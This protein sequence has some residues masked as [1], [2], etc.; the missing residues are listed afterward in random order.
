MGETICWTC[1]NACPN[2]NGVGCRWSM[3]GK[4]IP[5]WKAVRRDIVSFNH[6]DRRP[7]TSYEVQK[8][9][10]YKMDEHSRKYIEQTAERNRIRAIK[11]EQT[12]KKQSEDRKRLTVYNGGIPVPRAFCVYRGGNGFQIQRCLLRLGQAVAAE[13]IGIPKATLARI[14]TGDFRY[15]N[16]YVYL[17]ASRVYG[18]TIDDLKQEK[19]T[20]EQWDKLLNHYTKQV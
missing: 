2:Y 11:M 9:P 17:R 18:C 15:V 12:K 10:E 3:E 20:E 1:E 14:E 6:A 16:N 19:P 4:S 5:G 7:V 8:C 13:L